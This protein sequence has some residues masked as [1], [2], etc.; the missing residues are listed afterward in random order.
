MTAALAV[1]SA[2]A[3]LQGAAAAEESGAITVH[4]AP[5]TTFTVYKVADYAETG[6]F[7]LTDAFKGAQVKNL[8]T[9]IEDGAIWDMS[10]ASVGGRKAGTLAEDLKRQIQAGSIK[11]APAGTGKTAESG[12]KGAYSIV[13][14]DKDIDD[15]KG[16]VK[17]GG[18]GRGLYLLV[19]DQIVV[20]D[21][22][23]KDGVKTTTE[24]TYTPYSTLFAM[25][26]FDSE[27]T[28]WAYDLDYFAKGEMTELT[29]NEVNYSV[30]KVWNGDNAG[31]RPSS[32]QIRILL[33]GNTFD[34]VTLNS[35]N[36]WTRSWSYKWNGNPSQPVRFEVTEI[37]IP[38][39]YEMSVTRSGATFVVT[40]TAQ[41]VL[42]ATRGVLGATRTGDNTSSL[43]LIVF[44]G[45]GAA[46]IGFGLY[47]ILKKRESA[48][49][50]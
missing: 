20:Q 8:E 47:M 50:Q 9:I 2:L 38:Q 4:F 30:R 22:E 10:G 19:G 31:V 46:L 34:T 7:T 26:S 18:L 21:T 16:A 15:Y 44:A 35:S 33:N 45:S 13:G 14:S 42:G 1:V 37:N 40:N 24:K 11:P 39:N 23:T 49:P 48:D 28:A 6:E 3:P 36:N 5:G 43:P 27:N 12:A 25:P 32:V 17:I 29:E 41:G